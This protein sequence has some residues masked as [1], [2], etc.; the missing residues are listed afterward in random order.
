MYE[1]DLRRGGVDYQGIPWRLIQLGRPR[2]LAQR[3]QRYPRYTTVTYDPAL[4][5]A[6]ATV[7]E[8]TAEVY[9]FSRSFLRQKPTIRHFQL[10]NLLWSPNPTDVYFQRMGVPIA[11]V[12]F[13]RD[14][15]AFC[16]S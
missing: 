9:H 13:F 2:Y 12:A 4:V 8:E 1:R 16:F 11:I 10:L 7:C 5:Q 14:L 3:H 15:F 6:E